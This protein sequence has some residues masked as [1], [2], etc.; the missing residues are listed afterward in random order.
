MAFMEPEVLDK[1][2][3][4]E[5]ETNNGTSWVPIDVLS[6][7]EVQSARRGDYEPL[8]K[9][10]EGTKVYS[11]QSRIRKGYG[12]RLS[13]PGYMDATEWEIYGSKKEALKR[14][15]ELAKEA[16]GED[17]A[18]KKRSSAHATKKSKP[19]QKE[20]RLHFA[21][22][23]FTSGPGGTVIHRSAPDLSGFRP[24]D[25][26]EYQDVNLT[27]QGT[28]TGADGKWIMVRW[29]G[30]SFESREWAPNLRRVSMG[31]AHA[32]RSHHATKKSPAQ[33]DREIA[34]ATGLGTWKKSDQPYNSE[35][36]DAGH[37]SA[38]VKPTSTY[39]GTDYEWTTWVGPAGRRVLHQSGE[40]KTRA[41]AKRIAEGRLATLLNR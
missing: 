22:Y 29:D 6:A 3:W 17:Y 39:S 24:G 10:T 36:L 32:L 27:Q 15:R 41:R 34:Q 12:V 18:T 25:R 5:I 20:K 31:T 23:D 16:A 38:R 40:A 2:E 35:H 26:V 9:Y 37:A 14:A 28:V 33:L 30:R 21:G 8:L 11:D 19:Q 4:V 13:A 1:Q 7:S